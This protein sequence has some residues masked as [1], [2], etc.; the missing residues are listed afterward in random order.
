M[1]DAAGIDVLAL[2][3]YLGERVRA[4]WEGNLN[5]LDWERDF[6]LDVE[7]PAVGTPPAPGA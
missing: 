5:R 2:D 7:V 1:A 4:L 3:G 6:L